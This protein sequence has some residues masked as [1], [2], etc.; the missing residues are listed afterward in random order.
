[1]RGVKTMGGGAAIVRKAVPQPVGVKPMAGRADRQAP[2]PPA[3]PLL[4][5]LFQENIYLG[6]RPMKGGQTPVLSATPLLPLLIQLFQ[7]SFKYFLTEVRV[8]AGVA[9]WRGTGWNEGVF[10]SWEVAPSSGVAEQIKYFLG[11]LHLV[12]GVAEMSSNQGGRL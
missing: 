7:E 11:K 4:M 9:E 2:N 1:M 8:L 12:A 3:T 5:E 10:F 6:S